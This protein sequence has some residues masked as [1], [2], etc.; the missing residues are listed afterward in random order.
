[1]V[2]IRKIQENSVQTENVEVA[3]GNVVVHFTYDSSKYTGNVEKNL[4][5]M[6]DAEGL[7]INGIIRM[8]MVLLTGWDVT[9]Y[10]PEDMH[11][12]EDQRREVPLPLTEE[13]MAEMFG[14]TALAKIINA[15]NAKN[16]MGKQPVKP[17]PDF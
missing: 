13:V 11:L 4:K 8:L 5:Q 7:P 16:E 14:I 3:F 17:T 12:P 15:I 6:M 10:H 2:N 9:D 1:M